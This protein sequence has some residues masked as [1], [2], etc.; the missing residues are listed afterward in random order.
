M[1]E[2]RIIMMSEPK[3]SCALHPCP[4]GYARSK[5]PIRGVLMCQR[6]LIDDVDPERFSDE[7]RDRVLAWF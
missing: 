4:D 1:R 7:L 6:D 3:I 2:A 5:M